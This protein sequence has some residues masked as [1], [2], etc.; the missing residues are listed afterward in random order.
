MSTPATTTTHL[1]IVCGHAIW[2]GGPSNG[3]DES[4][5][6]IE[7]YKKGET[8]TFIAHIKAGCDLLN[9]DPNSV[10]VFSGAPTSP[11]TQTSEARSYFSLAA[12]NGYFVPSSSSDDSKR[13][14]ILLEE[15]ALDSYHNILFSLTLFFSAYSAWPRRVTIISHEFKRTR[16]V[17]GHCRAIGY[18]LDRVRYVGINPPG[19]EGKTGA[20]EGSQLALG[21]WEQDPH[22]R[23]EELASK[24]VARNHWGVGQGLF[25][26]EEVRGR[27]G[28][29]TVEYGEGMEA[30]VEGGRRP[31]ADGLV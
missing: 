1:I 11:L 14:R 28:V 25:E 24:R 20:M 8:P 22:G 19:V 4:E 2:L 13:K 5:W 21:Q 9:S 12:A 26:S 18:P 17:E 6:L 15:R 30:L 23:G 27:S 7:A 31:W 3:H 10:L 16:L 29:E